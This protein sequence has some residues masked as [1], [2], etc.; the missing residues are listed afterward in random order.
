MTTLLEQTCASLD[1]VVFTH[2]GADRFRPESVLPE[3]MLG[4]LGTPHETDGYDL[5][6]AFPFLSCFM[7]EAR[8]QWQQ[9]LSYPVRSGSWIETDLFGREVPLEAS[10]LFVNGCEVLILQ[11]LGE[12]YRAEV[13]LLQHVRDG[14]L[15]QEFLEAEVRKRTGEIR[16][17]EEDIA[18]KL[19][20]LTSFRDQ[21]TGAHVRRIGLY[22][23]AMA[24]ALD[25][26]ETE[27]DNIRI[28][29]PMHDIGKIGIPDNIL[30]KPGAL[31]EDEFA[32]IKQHARIGA[33]MLSGTDIP[34]LEMAAGIAWCHHERWDGSGY[35]RGLAGEQ[36]PVAARITTIVDIYDALIH[37]RVYKRAFDEAEAVAIMRGLSGKNLD[38][39]LLKVFLYLLPV[40]RRI[41]D[42]V[43]EE[44]EGLQSLALDTGVR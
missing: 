5:V 12:K 15:N 34:V 6:D 29:A 7:D 23:A 38:P 25:W 42:E 20:S 18:L 41:K 31:N 3:W 35:P 27:V 11:Q 17:R 33:E 30:L 26:S 19:I 13:T 4:L 40:M 9:A 2:T 21:E 8:S 16:Q 28:A 24:R 36:I 22:A 44:D 14:L 10:A 1:M 32:I 39:G 37:E 43:R